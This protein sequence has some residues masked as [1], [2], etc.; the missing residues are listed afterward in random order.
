MYM[1]PVSDKGSHLERNSRYKISPSDFFFDILIFN[2]EPQIPHTDADIPPD[3]ILDIAFSL[4]IILA[5]YHQR[6]PFPH[7]HHFGKPS[8]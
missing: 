8:A 4:R 7:N 1:P 3:Y 5:L 6:K 2:F